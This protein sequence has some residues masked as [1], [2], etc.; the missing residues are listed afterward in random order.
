MRWCSFI[1]LLY[2]TSLEANIVVLLPL[3]RGFQMFTLKRE[4][5]F[6]NIVF[7]L[8][9]VPVVGEAEEN[10]VFEAQLPSLPSA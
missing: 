3:S 1:I 2:T 10:V 7:E 5:N 9:S 6:C 4:D 8:L